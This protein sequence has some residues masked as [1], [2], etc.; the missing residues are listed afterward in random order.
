MIISKTP[1]RIPLTGGGTDLDF[2]Y[3]KKNGSLFSL[4]I[5]QYVYVHLHNREID[6][7]YLVQTSK[8]EFA[9]KI[10]QINHD[11]IRETLKYFGLKEKL[12]IATYSTVPTNTGLGSS[13][14][15]VV[16][17]INCIKKFKKLS[18]KSKEIIKI[19]YKIERK[20]CKLYGG[21]QDQIIS[22]TGGLIKIDISKKENIKIKKY[23][24]SP[25]IKKK[26]NDNFLL[27]YTNQKRNSSSI[28]LS[29]KK[30]KTKII[31]HYDKIKDLNKQLLFA[32]K[33]NNPKFIADIFNNHWE[34][35]KKLSDKM[36]NSHLNKLFLRL[37]ANYNFL[38]GKLIGACG[39]G[40]FLMITSNKKKSISL[41]EKYKISFID[42]KIENDGSRIIER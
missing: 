25:A 24:N 4:A 12:H 29:Q 27:V 19:A 41:L 35:K 38:G 34:F 21:W 9:N 1:Y 2:Y 42:F 39:G 26:I 13:S 40:F 3:K 28:A 17:L 30:R 18:I 11:L 37:L 20:I 5:N 31:E 8:I 33:N 32:M 36:T 14:A 6:R 15:M 16:G 23:Q 7:N 10:N 22:Q